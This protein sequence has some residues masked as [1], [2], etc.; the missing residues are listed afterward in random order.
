MKQFLKELAA[1]VARSA[2]IRSAVVHL[3]YPNVVRCISGEIRPDVPSDTG[4]IEAM[5]WKNHAYLVMSEELA[6]GTNCC[7]GPLKCDYGTRQRMLDIVLAAIQSRAGDVFEFGVA[8][9][10][11]FLQFL[12]RCPNRQVYGFDSFEGLPE[13]WWTRP[14]GTFAAQPPEFTNPNGHLIKG[15]YDESVPRFFRD[16]TGSIALLHIDCDLYSSTT[17]SLGYALDHCGANTVVLF[18]EYYN[19]PGFAWHEWLAW[20]EA[21]EDRSIVAKCLAYD[22]RRAAFQIK[23]LQE[24]VKRASGEQQDLSA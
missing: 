5:A 1:R 6:S 23:T 9:G 24:H 16:W 18:D 4:L 14:K 3:V 10:D 11:S 7:H 8:S 13:E 17:T 15:W 22:G 2:P 12:D 19:Y 21:K 20:K